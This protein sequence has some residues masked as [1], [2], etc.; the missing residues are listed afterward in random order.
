MDGYLLSLRRLS[1]NKC[2]FW[3][4]ILEFDGDI[5]ECL[6]RHLDRLEA[7]LLDKIPAGYKEIEQLLT[8]EFSSN[9]VIN[10]NALVKSFVWDLL[11]YL[12]HSFLEYSL[13]E[14]PVNMKQSFIVKAKAKDHTISYHIIIPNKSKAVVIVLATRSQTF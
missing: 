6:N 11:E 5:D 1:S 14:D 7:A 13:N 3:A 9:L 12:Q 8:H 2:D 4:E 10:D